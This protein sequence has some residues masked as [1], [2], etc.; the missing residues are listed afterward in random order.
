MGYF[1]NGTEGEM[2]REQY[3]D[4]CIHGQDQEKGCA[5]WDLHLQHNYESCSNPIVEAMLNTLIPKK[6]VFNGECKM[7]VEKDFEPEPEDAQ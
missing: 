5:V 2:Y 4:R 6:G 7:F 1:S 3:C